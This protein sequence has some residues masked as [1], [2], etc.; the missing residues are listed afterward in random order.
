MNTTIDWEFIKR[1]LVHWLNTPDNGYSGSDYGYKDT[2]LELIKNPPTQD[3]VLRVKSKM[4]IDL[5]FLK[6]RNAE[7]SWEAGN[8]E[9]LISIDGNQAAFHLS[10]D[11]RL[12]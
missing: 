10:K 8:E 9:I 1:R 12:E 6:N 3:A 4:L 2:I 7:V 5:P 11:T